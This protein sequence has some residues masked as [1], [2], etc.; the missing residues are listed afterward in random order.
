MDINLFPR[1]EVMPLTPKTNTVTA[2]PEIP[3]PAVSVEP[4]QNTPAIQVVIRQEPTPTPV[5]AEPLAALNRLRDDSHTGVAARATSQVMLSSLSQTAD[6]KAPFSVANVFSQIS[7]L[8]KETTEYRNEARQFKVPQKL[9]TEKFSPDFAAVRGSKAEAVN[10][11]V[12]TK[13]GDTIQIQMSRVHY[14]D[15]SSGIEF[16]F[17]VDGNLSEAEQKALGQLSDKLAQTSDTFFRTGTTELRGLQDID[18]SVISGF[19]LTLQR[20][21]GDSVEMHSYD[22]RV[23]DVAQTQT[24]SAEDT[25]GYKVDITSSLN[26][27]VKGQGAD[28]KVLQQYIDLIRRAGDESHAPSETQRFILDAFSGFFSAAELAAVDESEASKTSSDKSIAAFDSG[29]PDFK[30]SFRSPVGHNRS[31]YSQASAMVLTIEQ[32]T[33][34]EINQDS[35]LIKQE[36]SYELTNNRF[37]PLPGMERPDF[38]GGNYLYITQ[39]T[40]ASTSC[41]MSLT[42]DRVNNMWLEQDVADKKEVSRFENHKQVDQDSRSYEDRNLQDFAELLEKYSTNRQQLA[43]EDLLASSKERL[44]LGSK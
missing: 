34:I 28:A 17:V 19:N 4:E 6:G 38:V 29:L 26:P 23:D 21:K 40:T 11:N 20:P 35:S 39:K 44:F 15:G 24:L 37:A 14:K 1:A 31:N 8:S 16:S 32:K 10:L 42:G 36:S 13:E 9:L 3:V 12:R 2:L 33:R 27:L 30:A 18:T 7:S 22:Y 41:I 5:Y 25:N 43:V